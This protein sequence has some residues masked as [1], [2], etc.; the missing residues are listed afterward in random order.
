VVETARPPDGNSGRL[1]LNLRIHIDPMTE[2]RQIFEEVWRRTP[3][4]FYDPDIHGADWDAVRKRYE[5]LV[6]WVATAMT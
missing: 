5:P 2:W 3:A 1:S 4:F 6:E